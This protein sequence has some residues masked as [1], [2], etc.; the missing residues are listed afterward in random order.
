[1][2]ELSIVMGIVEIAEEQMKKEHAHHIDQIELD[3]GIMS[4]IEFEALDFAWDAGVRNTV[5]SNAERQI[6]RIEAKARC[7]DCGCEYI[8]HE[9]FQQCPACDGYMNEFIQGKELRIKSLVVS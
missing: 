6:N 8:V 4:G 9:P 3:I 2:H 7:L 5:L 1:M